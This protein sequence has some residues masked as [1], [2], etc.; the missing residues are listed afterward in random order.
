MRP[1]NVGPV[2]RYGTPVQATACGPLRSLAMPSN[3]LALVALLC[4]AAAAAAQQ[5]APTSPC[6]TAQHRQFDFWIG[7]WDVTTPDGKPAG[8]SLIEPILGRCVIHERWQGGG[9]VLGESFN[10]YNANTGQWEQYWVDS[11]GSRLHLQ[12]GYA[13]GRM[14]LRGEQDKPDAKTGLARRERITWTAQADGSVRQLWESSTDH[15][16]T[17]KTSFDGRYR[18]ARPTAAE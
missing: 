6:E 1:A 14:L 16:K 17:W 10:I 7:E 4:V 5:P 3:R 11:S 9:G 12:G 8:H 2:N 13:Q 18:R 15:G